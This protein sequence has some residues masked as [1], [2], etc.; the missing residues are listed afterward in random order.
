MWWRMCVGGVWARVSGGGGV[1]VHGVG[2]VWGKESKT[3]IS[4][5]ATQI[6]PG[7]V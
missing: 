1:D 2:V 5:P 7:L 6:S 3:V 4:Y